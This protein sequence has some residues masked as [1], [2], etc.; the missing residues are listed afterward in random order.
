M[1]RLLALPLVAATVA[2]GLLVALPAE[3]AAPAVVRSIERTLD[4][5][6]TQIG[7]HSAEQ[8]VHVR[9]EGPG[10]ASGL[11]ISAPTSSQF[12]KTATTCGSSLAN[13]ATCTITLRFAPTKLGDLYAAIY[14]TTSGGV[15]GQVS[16]VGNPTGPSLAFGVTST[17]L[18]FGRV[19]VGGHSSSQNVKVFNSSTSSASFTFAG[20]TPSGA[21]SSPATTCTGS[22]VTL[23]AGGSCTISYRFDPTASG[24]VT[25]SAP[26]VITQTSGG[27]GSLAYP[28]SLMGHGGTSSGP[29]LRVTPR[30]LD[31]GRAPIG[32]T[33]SSAQQIVFTNQSSTT[34]TF[35]FGGG[36]A[37]GFGNG[38]RTCDNTE[39]LAPGASCYFSYVADPD[40]PGTRKVES[41]Y[42]ASSDGLPYQNWRVWLQENGTG[43]APVPTASPAVADLGAAPIGSATGTVTFTVR[44]QG[45]GDWSGITFSR[46]PASNTTMEIAGSSCGSFIGAGISCNVTVKYRPTSATAVTYVRFTLESSAARVDFSAVGGPHDSVN[47]L[48]LKSAHADFLRDYPSTADLASQATQLDAGTIS[49]RGVVTGLAN[50]TAWVDALV[51][52]LYFDTLGRAG[53]S[54]G[55]HFWTTKILTG[56]K[57]VAQV[58]AAFYASHEYY[59]GIGGGTDSTWVKDLYVKLLGREADAGGLSYW[60][61]QT[62]AHGRDDV[63]LRMY[64]SPESRRTRVTRLYE[65]L[66]HR[67][68][69]AAGRDYWA[70]RILGEGDIALAIELASSPEYLRT[71]FL[72]NGVFG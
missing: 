13:G 68:P 26:L 45:N 65:Q 70:G 44:N 59:V 41:G 51:Q 72:T 56:K 3:A 66:L 35:D 42:G 12:E 10:V 8:T 52:R 29:V 71:A 23:A 1:K 24:D 5:G 30:A 69:D 39:T 36:A 54:G 16:L 25:G 11:A 28:V 61:G 2:A 34:R 40:R 67:E 33:G 14:Y 50:S 64:Q 62:S 32:V 47:T 17:F 9:N 48:F 60:V 20:R 46:S 49:R 6:S 15:K 38:G 57:T 22:P 7:L 27:G 55:V 31:F 58:A 19:A 53:D 43:T 4:F 63:A 21:F 18:D 37:N